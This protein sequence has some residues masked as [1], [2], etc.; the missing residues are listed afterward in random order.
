MELENKLLDVRS[1]TE[2]DRRQNVAL[3]GVVEAQNAHDG[4]EVALCVVA[5]CE[6]V[7]D[8]RLEEL[9]RDGGVY[10]PLPL[11]LALAVFLHLRRNKLKQLKQF[12]LFFCICVR[13][14]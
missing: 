12:V 3:L 5:V 8:R 10:L 13:I 1:R 14:N 4:A 6:E 11:G 9:E 2:L 7:V